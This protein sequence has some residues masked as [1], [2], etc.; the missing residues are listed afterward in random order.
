MELWQ[1]SPLFQ[2]YV[3]LSSGD[4]DPNHSEMSPH[5]CQ[6]SWYLKNKWWC[7]EEDVEK[8]ASWY[9]N[10]GI[11]LVHPLGKVG[12][13][14]LTALKYNYH[15]I[16]QSHFWVFMWRTEVSTSKRYLHPYVHCISID[17][18]QDMK[19]T[20][21]SLSRLMDKDNVYMHTIE[22]YSV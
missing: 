2:G 8:R 10:D 1:V 4:A 9:A 16:L 5:I 18:S 17:H 7:V 19:T 21:V 14:F 15:M 6:D 13:R 12:W 3:L 20:Q 11:K 22:Y